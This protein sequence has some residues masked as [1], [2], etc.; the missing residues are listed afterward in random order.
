MNELKVKK[1]LFALRI[2]VFI[3]MLVWTIDKFIKPEHTGRIFKKFYM[4]EG[5]G[6]YAA[7]GI[8]AIQLVIILLFLVGLF[9]R[10]SYG[11]ILFIHGVSTFSTW[12]KYINPWENGTL[13]FFAAIPML[14]ACYAL[15]VLREEDTLFNIKVKNEQ[16]T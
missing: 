5:I 4:I 10:F 8:G 16:N 2:G 7:Y 15:Y 11:F 1:S 13:L 12:A 6:E 9:K 14:A 3:V